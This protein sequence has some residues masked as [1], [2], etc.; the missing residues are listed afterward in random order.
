MHNAGPIYSITNGSD[1]WDDIAEWM[2]TDF[3]RYNPVDGSASMDY[4]TYHAG[5]KAGTIAAPDIAQV[6]HDMDHPLL[7]CGLEYDHRDD[8]PA[9]VVSPV[10]RHAVTPD[11]HNDP[12]HNTL[13]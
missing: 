3:Y 5:R 6:R 10:V 4:P 9:F 11:W 13:P 2:A 1:F 12:S 7:Q 8:E